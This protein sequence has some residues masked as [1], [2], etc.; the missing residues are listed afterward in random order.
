MALPKTAELL[1]TR[2][3]G[4]LDDLWMLARRTAV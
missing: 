1:N 2:N 4:D 3:R